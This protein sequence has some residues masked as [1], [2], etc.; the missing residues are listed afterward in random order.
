MTSSLSTQYGTSAQPSPV[1]LNSASATIDVCELELVV[2]LVLPRSS[3]CLTADTLLLHGLVSR[4]YVVFRFAFVLKNLICFS[5]FLFAGI[6]RKTCRLCVCDVATARRLA[7]AVLRCVMAHAIAS[8]L[9]Q[10]LPKAIRCWHSDRNRCCIFCMLSSV[11]SKEIFAAG[12]GSQAP[13]VQHQLVD[14]LL[15]LCC[16]HWQYLQPELPRCVAAIYVLCA[17]VAP[18]GV[19]H[20]FL[21]LR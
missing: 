1:A 17:R 4:W 5:S 21:S 18:S 3:I 16:Q 7:L 2:Y 11:C 9:S 12:R 20:A 14:R 15:R 10:E 8:M 6:F 19:W 13:S